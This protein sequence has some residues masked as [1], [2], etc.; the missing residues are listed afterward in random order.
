MI[1]PISIKLKDK[2][3]FFFFFFF[4]IHCIAAFGT[5]AKC[6]KRSVNILTVPGFVF[7]PPLLPASPSDM[8]KNATLPPQQPA[9]R[10]P[11]D[12]PERPATTIGSSASAATT[13]PPL[14]VDTTQTT[15][16]TTTTS[17]TSTPTDVPLVTRDQS[18]YPAA[19]MEAVVPPMR[20]ASVNS[21]IIEY[22]KP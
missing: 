10:G 15:A 13:V 5:V 20:T 2:L 3:F 1:H 19:R 6:P 22:R 7:F 14:R 21:G 8:S 4:G 18:L 11:A 12:E 16:A 17:T 9:N